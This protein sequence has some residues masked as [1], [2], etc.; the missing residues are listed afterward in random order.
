VLV[1]FLGYALL[2]TLK[3]LLKRTDSEYSPAKALKRLSELHSV[4]IVLFPPSL[5]W[6][7]WPLLAEPHSC[8]NDWTRSKF[9]N[10][11]QTQP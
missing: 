10:V 8:Q 2:V 9:K 3:Y 6:A 4:D 5:P 11:V 7:P 1:A